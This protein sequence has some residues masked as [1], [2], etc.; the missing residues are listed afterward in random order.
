M[1]F[2]GNRHFRST[3][4]CRA[5]VPVDHRLTPQRLTRLWLSSRATHDGAVAPDAAPVV[6]TTDRA[7]VTV[8]E[9]PAKAALVALAEAWPLPL[10]FSE[11]CARVASMVGLDD[12]PP[13]FFGK[14]AVRLLEYFGAGLVELARHPPPF[15]LTVPERPLAPPL[16]R[17]L[18]RAGGAVPSLRHALVDPDASQRQVLELC[19]GTRD[20]AALAAALHITPAALAPILDGLARLALICAPA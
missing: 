6:F 3:L 16:A 12:D 1:D 4:L 11:L 15:T 8:R 5:G 19:D 7:A 10:H 2:L 20:R 17:Q 14:I 13:R 9:A 18:A